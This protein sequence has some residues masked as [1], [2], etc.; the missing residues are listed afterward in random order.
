MS[1][2]GYYLLTVASSLL[3]KKLWILLNALK[4]LELRYIESLYNILLHI[5][6]KY[7]TSTNKINCTQILYYLSPTPNPHKVISKI[8]AIYSKMFVVIIVRTKVD[9]IIVFIIELSKNLI[10]IDGKFVMKL[11]L[12]TFYEI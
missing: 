2:L 1:V 4:C 8:A 12:S 7:Y 6:Y 3:I 10:P 11:D 5:C 9:T